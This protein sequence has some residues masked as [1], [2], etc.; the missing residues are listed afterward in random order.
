LLYSIQAKG[1]GQADRG[2]LSNDNKALVYQVGTVDLVINRL[3]N[4]FS[5]SSVSSPGNSLSNAR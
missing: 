1:S 3:P 5:V 4:S 2:S